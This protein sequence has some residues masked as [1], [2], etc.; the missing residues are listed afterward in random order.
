MRH[1]SQFEAALTQLNAA[2]AGNRN[3]AGAY[4][5]SDRGEDELEPI[6]KSL[7]LEAHTGGRNIAEYDMCDTYAHMAK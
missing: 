1:D 7:R 4:A 3:Y 5:E 6:E 2:I